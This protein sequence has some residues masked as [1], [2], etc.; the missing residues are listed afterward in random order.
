MTLAK[1]SFGKYIEEKNRKTTYEILV[2]TSDTVLNIAFVRCYSHEKLYYLED[3]IGSYFGDV[4]R[5]TTSRRRGLVLKMLGANEAPEALYLN[6]PDIYTGDIT[7]NVRKIPNRENELTNEVIDKLYNPGFDVSYNTKSV[8]YLDQPLFFMNNIMRGEETEKQILNILYSEFQNDLLIRKH[9]K[10]ED[11]HYALGKDIRYDNN[12]AQW[13]TICVR[14]LHDSNILVGIHSTALV[15][16]KLI[17][18]KEPYVVFLY[19]VFGFQDEEKL[20]TFVGK[21]KNMY[22]DKEKVFVP[23]NLDELSE[24]L[25]TIQSRRKNV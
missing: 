11:N 23:E 1:K 4:R 18:N 6:Y 2:V 9:P 16:P 25:L 20:N 15:S 3:G 10:S 22:A 7:N 12:G 14:K 21:I 8:I 13:E 24:I 19:K 17:C 5:M